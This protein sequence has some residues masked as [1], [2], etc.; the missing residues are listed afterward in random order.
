MTIEELEELIEQTK[1][2]LRV[3][4]VS[5]EDIKNMSLTRGK[6]KIDIDIAVVDDLGFIFTEVN[7]I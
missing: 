3:C 6:D 4:N 1:E 7:I 2:T 5:E